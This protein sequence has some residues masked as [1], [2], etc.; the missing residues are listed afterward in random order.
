MA[1]TR[2]PVLDFHG[3][4]SVVCL[5]GNKP[6]ACDKLSRDNSLLDTGSKRQAPSYKRQ[7]SSAIWIL[8]HE[9]AISVVLNPLSL[10]S[11]IMDPGKSF[12]PLWP[13]CLI[14]IN[15][16][17]KCVKWKAIWCGENLIVLLLVTFNSRVKNLL[18]LLYPNTS[19]IPTMLRFSIRF[20]IKPLKFSFKF[21]YNLA[22]GPLWI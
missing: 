1:S 19:G 17:F 16:P 11:V 5:E 2:I 10:S 14:R 4:G 12:K 13:R 9:S 18:N 22:S 8:G 21:L 7:A 20:Q 6:Q 3:N 15:V